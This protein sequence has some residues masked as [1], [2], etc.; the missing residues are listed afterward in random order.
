MKPFGKDIDDII[1]EIKD[2]EG[3]EINI[4]SP[5]WASTNEPVI[6]THDT[7]NPSTGEGIIGFKG[8]EPG[9]FAAIMH[10]TTPEGDET[11]IPLGLF[12]VVL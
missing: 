7:H 4:S 11:N 3:Q 1:K 2:L 10:C 12:T 8:T 6:I 5:I 9:A